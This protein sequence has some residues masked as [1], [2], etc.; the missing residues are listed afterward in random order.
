MALTIDVRLWDGGRI[1]YPLPDGFTWQHARDAV[2]GLRRHHRHQVAR[3]HI[4]TGP[5]QRPV[6]TAVLA[7]LDRT[8]VGAL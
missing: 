8:L 5:V 1:E 4:V 6:G 7:R 2:E 3:A